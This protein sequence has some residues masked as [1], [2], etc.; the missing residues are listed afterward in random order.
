MRAVSDDQT[1]PTRGGA[2]GGQRQYGDAFRLGPCC[3][4]GVV[5][6]VGEE[7]DEVEPGGDAL[8]L[9]AR[10]VAPDCGHGGVAAIAMP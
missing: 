5:Q 8:D 4:C 9:A 3:E 7:G 2:V 6:V 1:R 10:Q